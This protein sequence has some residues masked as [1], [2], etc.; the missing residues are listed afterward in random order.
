L[1]CMLAWWWIADGG[2][3]GIRPVVSSEVWRVG[4]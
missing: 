3:A 1:V 4:C 2:V